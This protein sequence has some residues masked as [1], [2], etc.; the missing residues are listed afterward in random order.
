M[1]VLLQENNHRF[2]LF[3][4]EYD[5]IWQMYKQAE[6]SFWTAEEIDLQPDLK[7]WE[8]LTDD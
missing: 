2:V 6:A 4:I 7:D 5:K 3:P 1:E 8:N